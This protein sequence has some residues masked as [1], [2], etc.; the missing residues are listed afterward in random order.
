M[1]E[2]LGFI[3][4]GIMGK[5][6]AK[7]LINAGYNLVV[8]DINPQPVEEL[9][10]IGAESARSPSEV[11]LKAKKI[12][13]M[14]PDGPEVEEVVTG[15]NGIL[16][17]AN[18]ETVLIDMS[19][20]SPTVTSRIVEALAQKGA[21]A[22][23]APVSGGEPGAINGQLAIMVGGPVDLFDEMKPVFEVLGQ[24]A[25]LVGDTGAGQITKLV[26]QI[27]V[28]IHIEA[29][30]EAFLL[31]VKSGVEPMKV[32]NAIKGGLAGSNVL[33]AKVPLVLDRNFKPGFKIKLHRKDLKN[34]LEAAGNLG[35][36]LP[37][38]KMVQDMINS[39]VQDGKGEEDHGGI[40]QAMEKKNNVE[41][42]S[43]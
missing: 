42:K 10:G 38:T 31:A 27:L 20:I 6:M 36:D 14:L 12:I 19:S 11:A 30:G 7:N 23:D 22:L 2:T 13:T 26:N 17:N 28:G 43:L 8:N 35:L 18:Q 5:P 25:V 21:R 29:M 34:A 37:V 3:G 1:S 15:E 24:S 41:I 33:N 4:L 16:E 9:V 40:V 39:L 32:F